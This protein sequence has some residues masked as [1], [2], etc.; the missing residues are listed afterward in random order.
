MDMFTQVHLAYLKVTIVCGILLFEI[1]ADWYKTFACAN[2]S[3]T[4]S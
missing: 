2:K 1:F 4:S 3:F